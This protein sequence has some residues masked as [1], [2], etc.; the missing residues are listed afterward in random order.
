[1]FFYLHLQISVVLIVGFCWNVFFV[2][3]R[4]TAVCKAG[5]SSDDFSVIFQHYYKGKPEQE[6]A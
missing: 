3:V 2:L 5:Q 6:A 1:L 4:Y